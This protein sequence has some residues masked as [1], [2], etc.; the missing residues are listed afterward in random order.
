[1]F[2]DSHCHLHH[3]S[4]KTD[5][6]PRM[7]KELQADKYQF[8]MDIGTVAGDFSVRFNTVAQAWA[9]SDTIPPFIHFSAGIWPSAEAIAKPQQALSKLE[10]D[11]QT[12]LQRGAHYA[13]VGECG[14]DRYWNGTGTSGG[15][16]DLAGEENLFKHQLK[17]AQKYNLAVIVHSRDG[18]VPTLACI[19]EVGWH[20]GVIHCFSYGIEEAMAFIQRGW[21]ISFSGTVTYYKKQHEKDNMAAL[22]RCVPPDKILLETDSP[23]LAP[24]PKRGKTNTPLYIPY[25]YEQACRYLDCSMEYLCQT[26]QK[27][28][29]SLFSVFNEEKQA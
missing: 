9:Q 10:A 4:E 16:E 5:D 25:V 21:Y 14:I 3:L 20:K 6:L 26:V 23:Y 17:L 29:Q 7:L 18:F 27:N 1:M 2:T 13:A 28:C 24:V 15:S 22:M 12:I 19:D 11:I 8:V